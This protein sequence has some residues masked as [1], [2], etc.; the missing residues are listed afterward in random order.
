MNNIPFIL[1]CIKLCEILSNMLADLG[2]RWEEEFKDDYMNEN[3]EN[4]RLLEIEVLEND[5]FGVLRREC[6]RDHAVAFDEE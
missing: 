4:T 1:I 2:D 5:P 3:Y 6:T